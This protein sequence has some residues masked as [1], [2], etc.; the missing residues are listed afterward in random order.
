MLL[1]AP[2]RLNKKQAQSFILGNYFISRYIAYILAVA[3]AHYAMF[4]LV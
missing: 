1:W 2:L 4:W 3:K